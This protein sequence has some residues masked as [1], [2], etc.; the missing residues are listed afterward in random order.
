VGVVLLQR[1]VPEHV[2]QAVAK[3][4]AAAGV[5]VLLD[6]GGEARP[7]SDALLPHLTFLCPNELELQSLT[8]GA[9][10]DSLG[11]VGGWVQPVC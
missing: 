8:G 7:L 5:P 6:A 11:Q 3:A 4:A 10:T 1:E 2:N 9:P